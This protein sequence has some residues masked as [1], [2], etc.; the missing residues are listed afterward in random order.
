MLLPRRAES[1]DSRGRGWAAAP[2]GFP[3]GYRGARLGA[4]R[5]RVP[6]ARRGLHCYPR[7]SALSSGAEGTP[8]GRRQCAFQLGGSRRLTP[9]SLLTENPGA[10]GLEIRGPVAAVCVH[11]GPA[12]TGAGCCSWQDSHG[13]RSGHR[14]LSRRPSSSCPPPPPKAARPHCGLDAPQF[15]PRGLSGNCCRKPLRI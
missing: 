1:E 9:P 15:H 10:P 4:W 7:Y 14:P 8:Q 3:T 11:P 5:A 12:R 13:A 2:P 6:V